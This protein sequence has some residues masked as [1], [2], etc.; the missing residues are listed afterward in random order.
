MEHDGHVPGSQADKDCD[1]KK[2]EIL[3]E[4]ELD[5]EGV[6]REAEKGPVVT[7]Q[8]AAFAQDGI[9]KN[10]KVP[11]PVAFAFIGPIHVYPLTVMKTPA[12]HRGEIQ[13]RRR[14]QG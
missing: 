4:I 12:R 14:L 1:E 7:L 11:F 2:G 3:V 9:E 8:V 6:E 13:S 5:Q 10:P